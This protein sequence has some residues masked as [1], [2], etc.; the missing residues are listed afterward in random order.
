MR[1]SL[2]VA[3]IG[4]IRELEDLFQSL[5]LQ[6]HRDFEV[7]LVD[8]N[9]DDRLAWIDTSPYPFPIIR[10]RSNVHHLSHA[11][12]VG[13]GKAIGDIVAFPDDDCAYPPDLLGRVDEAF[14][15]QLDLGVRTGPAVT[16]AGGS[17][18]GRWRKDLGEIDLKN[19]WLCAIAFNMFIRRTLVL[20]I[21]GFDE[22]LG[23]GGQF[24]SAED[25]DLVLR[26][27]RAGWRG[28]YDTAQLAVHPDKRLSPVAAERAFAYGAGLGYALR[29]HRV[30]TWT[31]A[32]F[33][34]RPIGGCI[35]SLAAARFVDVK[36]Y[37][38]TLR[39]RIYGF[40]AYSEADGRE[41]EPVQEGSSR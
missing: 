26:A 10:T 28:W 12:N 35:T 5:S 9:D 14:R 13:L 37:W 19:V 25:S 20:S 8:Q 32:N 27:V 22:H 2:V 11:R 36:Y 34:I 41:Q 29:K 1:F 17:S 33:M 30:P 4:R 40:G 3:T 31:W 15:K 23:V 39:G 38:F 21:G 6:T 18:S 7:I 24:G 16:L